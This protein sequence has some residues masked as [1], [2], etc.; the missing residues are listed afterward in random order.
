MA[1]ITRAETYTFETDSDKIFLEHLYVLPVLVVMHTHNLTLSS[2]ILVLHYIYIHIYIPNSFTTI[3][4]LRS[5]KHHIVIALITY[6][7]DC[8][9]KSFMQCIWYNNE[10]HSILIDHVLSTIAKGCNK[11]LRVHMF[12]YSTYVWRP[13]DECNDSTVYSI[14]ILGTL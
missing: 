3:V 1:L 5:K 7:F 12:I 10:E 14:N 8:I 2:N 6:K 13:Q 11:S 9:A 4:S